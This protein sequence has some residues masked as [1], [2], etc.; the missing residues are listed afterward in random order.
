MTIQTPK[1]DNAPGLTWNR[2]KVGWE[3]RW[4]ARTD[5]VDAG[6]RFKSMRIWSGP[7]SELDETVIA[8]IQDRCR[9]LQD[10]MLE[11]ARGGLPTVVKEFDGTIAG[12]ID[13]YTTDPASSWKKL[14]YVSREHY[15]SLLRRLRL[16]CGA[17]QVSEIKVRVVV[18]LYEGWIKPDE[19]GDEPKLTMGHSVI[20]M[21]RTL[22]NFGA[23]IL[24]DEQ[25]ERVAGLLHR[26]KFAQGAPRSVILSY[27]QAAAICKMA[28][29]VGKPGIGLAQAIQCDFTW[30]QK[31]VIGEWVPV[32]EPGLSAVTSG[33]SKWLRGFRWE[34]VDQNGIVQHITSK[35]LK[36]ITIDIKNA[37]LVV[38]ELMATYPGSFIRN[39]ISGGLILNRALLPASGPVVICE[40]TGVPY[41]NTAFRR[42]WRQIATKCEVPKS[43]RNMDTRA[44]AITEA[45]QSGARP[46]AVRKSATHSNLSMTA[47]YS[48]SDAD[49]IAEVMQSRMAGRNKP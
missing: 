16:D 39:E 19:D 21:L 2:R 31:D 20:G 30:R 45:L 18:V 8:F 26:Q 47:R 5:I 3:A 17:M 40:R 23:G 12:L 7:E 14:R 49:D 29:E 34:E 43:V 13:S 33:N 48:R 27:P 10:D 41:D 38:A 44:G 1:I 4:Q 35:R 32:S 37:P 46:D 24:E 36:S 9:S 15:K 6:F 22:V 42:E 28:R 25:C 11:F